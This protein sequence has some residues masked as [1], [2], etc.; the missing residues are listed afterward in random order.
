ML[1]LGKVVEARSGFAC[2][3]VAPDGVPQFRMNNVTRDGRL[4]YTKVRRVPQDKAR[5]D[6][7][8]LRTGD[9]LFNATNSP[10]LVGKTALFIERDEPTVFSNHFLRIRT[11]GE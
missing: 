4:D 7:F 1:A 3:E 2:G 8:G 10:D 11:N 6:T 5:L 9:V